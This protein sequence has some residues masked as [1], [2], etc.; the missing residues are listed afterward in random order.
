M[1]S[2]SDGAQHFSS[3]LDGTT[4][5]VLLWSGLYLWEIVRALPFNWMVISGKKG[6][7]WG[8]FVLYLPF[9]TLAALSFV[10]AIIGVFP[11]QW[12]PRSV[13][14]LHYVGESVNMVARLMVYHM[15][16]IQVAALWKT[17]AVSYPL[18]AGML[19]VWAVS[20]FC[21]SRIRTEWGSTV[22]LKLFTIC[23]L[24][25]STAIFALFVAGLIRAR[26]QSRFNMNRRYS[27]MSP[28]AMLWSERV[29]FIVPLWVAQVIDSATKLAADR[30]TG[31]SA[32]GITCY[33]VIIV[34]GGRA[35]QHM[36]NNS[37]VCPMTRV[38]CLISSVVRST[39]SRSKSADFTDGS[40]ITRL[41][42]ER[43]QSASAARSHAPKRTSGATTGKRAVQTDVIELETLSS[44]DE[45]PSSA[46]EGTTKRPAT[47]DDESADIKSVLK[48]PD[49]A[50]SLDA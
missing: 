1:S 45:L 36:V 43:P 5:C 26:V 6:C 17:W 19:A 35:F 40:L 15:L 29:Q 49:A 34:S 20:I 10:F 39:K 22:M 33:I 37:N 11:P 47:D 8:I 23:L 32:I 2:A 25:L 50:L 41:S 7:R 16:T 3:S 38:P 42:Q 21:I 14:T 24:C 9:R 27:Q 18:V 28:L 31:V 46:S 12:Q 48:D 30:I 44:L 13:L 4:I